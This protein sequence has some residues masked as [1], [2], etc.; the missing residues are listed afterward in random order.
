MSQ[1]LLYVLNHSEAHELALMQQRDSNLARCY[2]D[3]AARVAD[4]RSDGGGFAAGMRHAASIVEGF[5]QSTEL[6]DELD[7]VLAAIQKET[8]P[9]NCDEFPTVHASL[10]GLVLT[11]PDCASLPGGGSAVFEPLGEVAQK[12]LD[13]IARHPF[14]AAVSGWDAALE[15]AA[16]AFESNDTQRYGATA[17]HAEIARALR[18]LKKTPAPPARGHSVCPGDGAECVDPALCKETIA[19]WRSWQRAGQT[20]LF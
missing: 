10:S 13:T 11:I 9:T 7:M 15:A 18:A 5:R 8:P 16:A 19:G 1:K 2:L 20:R 17:D 14:K 4:V 6:G 3:L 12:L